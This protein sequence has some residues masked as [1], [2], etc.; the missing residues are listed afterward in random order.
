MSDKVREAVR[1]YLIFEAA[2][3]R[4]YPFKKYLGEITDAEMEKIVRACNGRDDT[5][6]VHY[7]IEGV[8]GQA[9]DP[10]LTKEEL[11]K[12]LA[13]GKTMNELFPFKPGQ[14]CEIFK[15]ERFAPGD[16]II[17]IPDTS[18]NEIPMDDPV[19]SSDAIED[20]V[21]N[22]YTWYDFVELCGG[23]TELAERVFDYC[24][25]QHPSSA[26]PEVDDGEEE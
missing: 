3:S 11:K 6:T 10:K 2:T 5:E 16:A 23:D 1:D 9:G 7:A 13:S 15:A 25:W 19:T 22:C 17:Y 14:D 24:D 21:G 26:L 20:V 4:N 12:E 18:L 8:V